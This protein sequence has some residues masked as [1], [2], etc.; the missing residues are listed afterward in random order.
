MKTKFISFS[1]LNFFIL[2]TIQ[3][4]WTRPQ[5]Y[6]QDGYVDLLD[7][8]VHE[9]PNVIPKEIEQIVAEDWAD[10]WDPPQE[11]KE[12]FPYRITGKD[13]DGATGIVNLFTT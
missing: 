6:Q 4:S 10:T 9:D 1:G 2:I 11:M 5:D 13:D 12:W 3:P 7:F 8:Q